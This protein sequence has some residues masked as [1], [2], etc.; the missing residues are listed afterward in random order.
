V[1][2]LRYALRTLVKTPGPT[3]VITATLAIAIGAT[4]I[5]ASTI[6]G[7][8]HAI[9]AA[10][11]ERLVFV[12]STDPRPSQAQSG[13]T[14]NLAMTGTSVPDLVDWTAQAT[15]IEQF[16]AF[17][18][19]TATLTGREA[20]ARVSLVRTTAEMFALWG[21]APLVGRVFSTDDGR[22]GA[23]PVVLLSHRYWQESFASNPSVLDESVLLDG[24]AHSIVG[25]LP[26]SIRTGIFVDTD[27]FVALPLDGARSARDER[28]LFVTARLKG[29]TLRHW[30]GQLRLILPTPVMARFIR[31]IHGT[32][33]RHGAGGGAAR[34]PERWRGLHGP[35]RM[36]GPIKS[37]HD[38]VRERGATFVGRN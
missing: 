26:P 18:Y 9:P 25:V 16:G 20:P 33:R 11:T 19:G 27:L 7:V 35:G 37:G 23:A 22:I 30:S 17:R 29:A 8:W 21:I 4:T 34:A 10:R 5:I 36:D 32:S 2:P 12:A 6:D 24:V 15:T 1:L 14:G 28:R 31:A 3:F 13:M 38:S